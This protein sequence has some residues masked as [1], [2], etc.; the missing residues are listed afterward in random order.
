MPVT[1]AATGRPRST[2]VCIATPWVHPFC[3]ES[4][5]TR[6]RSSIGI[7]HTNA[8]ETDSP[9][10]FISVSWRVRPAAR[11]VVSAQPPAFATRVNGTP[12][13]GTYV[14]ADA[15]GLIGGRAVVGSGPDEPSPEL[16][17]DDE[18]DVD[19]KRARYWLLNGLPKAKPST[20]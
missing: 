10:S 7:A 20:S 18:S 12:A 16:T 11:A 14:V 6:G 13:N 4:L 17:T 15:G 8:V 1:I 19:E 2:P 3:N 9:C 5:L